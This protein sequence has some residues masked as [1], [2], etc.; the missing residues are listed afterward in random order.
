M[1]SVHGL[2]L[3]VLGR[4]E[5]G[6]GGGNMTPTYSQLMLQ[7]AVAML[8]APGSGGGG[9]LVSGTPVGFQNYML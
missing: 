5:W 6:G 1:V 4:S 7:A 8:G 3:H 2:H 9:S